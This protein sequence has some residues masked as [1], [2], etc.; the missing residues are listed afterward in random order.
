[1]EILNRLNVD[2]TG[3]RDGFDALAPAE[4]A[5]LTEEQRELLALYHGSFDDDRVDHMLIGRIVEEIQA[6]DDVATS[7]GAVLV[8]LPGY[9]DIVTLR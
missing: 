5:E 9:D 7:G 3:N 6:G 2:Q 4:V 1:M 8:F